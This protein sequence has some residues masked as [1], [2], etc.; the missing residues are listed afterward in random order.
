MSYEYRR[1]EPESTILY[2][3]VGEHLE[4]FLRYTREHY[5]RPLPR[6]VE[7]ELRDYLACGVLSNGFTRIRCRGCGLDVLLAF[8]CKGRSLCPSCGARR[9]AAGA[10]HIVDRVLPDAPV[11][12]WVLSAPWELRL[13]L[14]AQAPVLS[15]V[16]R[17]FL[18]VVL[19]WYRDRAREAG[20]GR[21]ET[22]AISVLQRFGGSLNLHCH[23]H[24]V[25]VD[26]VYCRDEHGQARF[27]F[28]RA[29]TRA[30]IA[31]VAR[32]SSERIQ[33]MLRQG[34]RAALALLS[35]SGSRA[36]AA[37]GARGRL[38]R[39]PHEVPSP[40]RQD[41]SGDDWPRIHGPHRGPGGPA[42]HPVAPLP[43]HPRSKLQLAAARGARNGSVGRSGAELCS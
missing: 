10:A 28:V 36:R 15:A 17:I 32:E 7:R 1:H 13:L 40:G 42:A 30:D 22:G 41:A 14:A 23:I 26:G 38:G 9:M 16:L 5:A 11:R 20:L 43:R 8:S 21:A 27:H 12:Q 39:V 2:A 24:A 25:L 6:Y 19:R 31:Q 4:P 35:A 37:V 3:L 33:K 34:T 18:R 29:P